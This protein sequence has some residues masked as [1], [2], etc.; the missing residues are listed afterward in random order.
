MPYDHMRDFLG[1]VQE[2]PNGP[3][4]NRQYNEWS[5][6]HPRAWVMKAAKSDNDDSPRP[7]TNRVTGAWSGFLDLIKVFNPL[8]SS[9]EIC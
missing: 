4:A 7:L 6:N 5:P 2:I 8:K 3:T 9:E 1:A